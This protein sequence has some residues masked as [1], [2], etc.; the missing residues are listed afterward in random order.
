M[1]RNAGESACATA[2]TWFLLAPCVFA[3]G[4]SGLDLSAID[5]SAD[6]CKNFYQYAC[7][8]WLKANPIP[9]D[10]ASWGRFDVLFE[11]NQ[12]ILQSILED[13]EAHM[14]RSPTDQKV[15]GF[16]RSC[17]AEDEIQRLGATPLRPEL[18]RIAAIAKRVDL[19]NEIARLHT[20][21]VQVFFD[22]SS[23]PDPDNAR[24][25]IANLDQG[26]LGLP[27]KDF[28][29]RSDARSEEIR[30][31]YVAHIGKMLELSGTVPSVAAKQAAERR[32]PKDRWISR[33]AATP[34]CWCIG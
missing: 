17:M 16:Y 21:Q 11:S 26:G 1:V 5:K 33:P 4:Q 31:K 18:E 30:Q 2:L 24:R 12:K 10:E 19:L 27:E 7:G 28:Y 20:L 34:S 13:S 25:N 3:Q 8:G 15:G 32:L 14:E 22:F 23:S 9:P 6:P 29:F